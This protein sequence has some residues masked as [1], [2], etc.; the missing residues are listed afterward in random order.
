MTRSFSLDVDERTLEF[1]QVRLAFHEKDI[2]N[3]FAAKNNKTLKE[4]LVAPRYT[5]LQEET[6]LRYRPF[7]DERLGV[8]LVGLKQ[9]GD[10]FYRRFLNPYG[11]LQYCQ[12][13]I[14]DLLEQKGLYAYVQGETIYYIGRCRDGFG[15]RI[16][17]GYG[18]IFPK[19]CYLDGQS[20]NCH[21]NS[22]I[23]QYQEVIQFYVCPLERNS[24]IEKFE[25]YLIELLHPQWNTALTH[26]SISAAGRRIRKHHDLYSD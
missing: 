5:Y 14:S 4:T 13:T 24:E 25:R 23:D 22:L 15:K 6:L 9:S 21:L 20:T 12:F 2:A 26:R 17:Q 8:F 3:V 19:N 16:N 11:D 10:E 7:L 18:R 1:Q